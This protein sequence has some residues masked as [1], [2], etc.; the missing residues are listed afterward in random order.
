[1]GVINT[2][3][4]AKIIAIGVINTDTNFIN[5]D[6]STNNTFD[7]VGVPTAGIISPGM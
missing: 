4:G 3:N 5:T 2:H 6:I 7:S 1:M